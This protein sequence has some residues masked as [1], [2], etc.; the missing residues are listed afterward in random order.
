M[1]RPVANWL[2]SKFLPASRSS[3]GVPDGGGC[4]LELE[5]SLEKV[6]GF[7]GGRGFRSFS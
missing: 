6:G 2:M 7:D 4:R 5:P 3:P 1:W